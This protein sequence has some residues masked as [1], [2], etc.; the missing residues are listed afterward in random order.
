MLRCSPWPPGLV[1]GSWNV[2]IFLM[3]SWS[4]L[5]TVCV[6]E[7]AKLVLIICSS[8]PWDKREILFH[9]EIYS[10]QSTTKD[11]IRWGQR[12]SRP[13]R[14]LPISNAAES[15]GFLSPIGPVSAYD[16]ISQHRYL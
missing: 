3:R 10:E 4:P 9:G 15:S 16:L 13:G 2:L 5:C 11:T 8:S 1:I 6:L 14:N 7:G 12:D